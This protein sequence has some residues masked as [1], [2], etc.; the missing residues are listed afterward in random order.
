MTRG[1][2][3]DSADAGQPIVVIGAGMAGCEAAWHLAG[4]GYPVRLF[5]MRPQR[6][7]A[8]HSTGNFAELVCSNSFRGDSPANAVG[9]LKREMEALGSL[10]IGSARETAVPAGGA[11]AVDRTLF[12]ERVT[13]K[14]SSHPLISIERQ[15]VVDLPAGPVIM[16]TG[17]LTSPALH[18]AVQ[19]LL[20]ENA[21]SFF[22]AVA[23][24]VAADSLDFERLFRASRYDKGEGADYLNAGMSRDQYEAFIDQLMAAERVEF[25]EFE[26]KDIK[27]F[28]GCLPIEVM[29]ERGR[30]TLRF[31]PMKPVGLVDPATDA[32]PWAVVQLR[33][34]DVAA[35][36]WNLVGFQTKLKQAEQQRVLRMIPG[37]ERARFV[38]FGMVH[39]NTYINAPVHLD[40]F[41]R[42]RER[43]SVR[44]AGQMTGVEGYVES[45]ATGLLAAKY[46]IMERNGRQT[47]LPPE[48]AMGGLIRHLTERPA[49]GFQ[50]SNITWG[51]LQCPEELRRIRSKRDRRVAQAEGALEAIRTWGKELA[52]SPVGGS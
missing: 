47:P 16:A 45:A 10:I 4:A 7:T 44:V 46:I 37:L 26:K 30:D 20:G 22:D 24:V 29:A 41:L 40:S 3:H 43:P 6:Q 39:R 27:Y 33:Q 11:L 15:E 48:T 13:K 2:G 23:P 42:L 31:G 51:L 8:V 21:L 18:T 1:L 32:R 49:K 25:Q 36:Q 12:S 9:L 35:E 38:R 17:P 34:D 52:E 28:E 50:P 19:A 5:E 14:I